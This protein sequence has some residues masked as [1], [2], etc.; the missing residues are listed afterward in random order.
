[1]TFGDAISF[2]KSGYPVYKESWKPGLYVV[3]QIDSDISS[4]VVP[5]MQSL[6]IQAKKLVGSCNDESIHYRNQCLIIDTSSNS[7]I[8]TNYIPDWNDMMST[9]WVHHR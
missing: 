2:L 8:A 3:K 4:D 6:P 7:T 9:D 5:N 1:M